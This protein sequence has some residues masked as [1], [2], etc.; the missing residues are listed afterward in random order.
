MTPRSG[1]LKSNSL[2]MLS[3]AGLLGCGSACSSDSLIPQEMQQ[4]AL[5][6]RRK[7]EKARKRSAHEQ[8]AANAALQMPAARLQ[9]LKPELQLGA[10][11][12]LVATRAEP[13]MEGCGA[14]HAQHYYDG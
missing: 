10:S 9:A 8:R 12:S 5:T 1:F 13:F 7:E 2:T 6:Q 11:D 4:Q 3:L 14:V